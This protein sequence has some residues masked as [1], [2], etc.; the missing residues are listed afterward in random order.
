MSKVFVID[1]RKQPLNP[2]HPGYA[3]KLLTE[4]KAAVFRKYPFT[5]I[6]KREVTSEG[7]PLRLKID[8]G[9]KTTGLAIINDTSGEVVWAAELEH[10]GHTIKEALAKRRVI[11]RLRRQRKTRYR[12]PRYSNRRRKEGWLL[13]SLASRLA[14]IMTWVRRLLHLCPIA[15]ISQEMVKFD[16]QFLQNP[17]ISGVEYQQGELAGYEVREYLLEKWGRQCVYCGAKNIPLQVEHILCRARGGTNRISNLTLA[18]GT[19]NISKGTRLVHDF[20]K[21]KPDVLEKLL[22]QAKAS[23]KDTA[24]NATRWVL[25][26][27]LQALGLPVESDTGGKTKYNRVKRNLPKMH[28]IDAACIGKSTPEL[29]NIADVYPL[30]IKAAGSGNRRMCSMNRYGFPRSASKQGKKVKGFQTGDIVRAVVT[31]G[32]KRGTYVGR[33]VVRSS[34][35]FKIATKQGI[36]EGINYRFCSPLHRCDGYSYQKGERTCNS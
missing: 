1:T 5:I 26:R 31:V 24:I 20:L 16:T 34:G 32:K 25:Y 6:L 21:A 36:V 3:R 18:C 23:L 4:G 28:W 9:S 22:V 13:P 8:P 35:S 27:N 30:L 15:A 33:L 19:C 11:R 29:L 17:E 14:N 10:R 12:K 2:I 7:I